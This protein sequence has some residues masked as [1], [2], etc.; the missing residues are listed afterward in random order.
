LLT[1][2]GVFPWRTVLDNVLLLVDVQK[3]GRET[4]RSRALELLS[5]VGP[6]EAGA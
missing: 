3:L 1:A 4:N 2:S 6:C 5:V